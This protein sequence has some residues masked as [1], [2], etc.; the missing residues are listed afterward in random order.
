MIA[1]SA[2]GGKRSGDI[3]AN[4]AVLYNPAASRKSIEINN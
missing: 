1:R 2:D 3:F 4:L